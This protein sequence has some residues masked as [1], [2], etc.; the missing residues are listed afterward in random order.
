MKVTY[1]L[2]NDLLS[3]INITKLT[4][5]LQD[6]NIPLLSITINDDN[7][8]IELN[9]II[10]SALHD[11]ITSIVTSHDG[12]P[13][14][15]TKFHAS[16]HILSGEVEITSDLEWQEIAGV[17]S[18]PS[19]FISD[20]NTVL[21]RV[22]GSIKHDGGSVEVRLVEVSQNGTKV[23]SAPIELGENAVSDFHPFT[24]QNIIPPSEGESMY[25]I[26]AR[27]N[28]SNSASLKYMAITL[29]E[30]LYE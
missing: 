18:N 2:E 13:S 9:D 25:I 10:S 20:L 3:G 15:K 19:Y 5:E 6:N 29:M 24:L 11:E 23:M 14:L 8:D 28:G 4:K 16:S 27:L 22:T 1:S 17:Y 26:E 7:V 21:S 30:L 12:Q